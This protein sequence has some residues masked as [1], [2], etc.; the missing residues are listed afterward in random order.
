MPL[1]LVRAARRS[2]AYFTIDLNIV[3]GTRGTDKA[4]CHSREKRPPFR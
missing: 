4:R 2:R 1:G 3:L